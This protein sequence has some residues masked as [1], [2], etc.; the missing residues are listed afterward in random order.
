MYIQLQIFLTYE[1]KNN[2]KEV[3]IQTTTLR[4][5]ESCLFVCLHSPD[6]GIG[7]PKLV[8]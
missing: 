4:T 5:L 6:E 8:V 3:S 1:V 2:G 7:I